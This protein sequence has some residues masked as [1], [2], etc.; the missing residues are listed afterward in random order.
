MCDSA[1]GTTFVTFIDS[2]PPSMNQPGASR[3]EEGRC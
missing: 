2:H 1:I 3:Q